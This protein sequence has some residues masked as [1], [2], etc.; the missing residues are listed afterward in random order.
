MVLKFLI[1]FCWDHAIAKPP[2]LFTFTRQLNIISF[3]ELFYED[4]A[5]KEGSGICSVP[6]GIFWLEIDE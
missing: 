3:K 5:K 4:K 2:H 6:S 1:N